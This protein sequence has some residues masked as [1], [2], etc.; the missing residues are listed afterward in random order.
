MGSMLRPSGEGLYSTFGGTAHRPCVG[1]KPASLG[2]AEA[3]ALPLTA[4]TAYE[5]L[6]DRLDRDPACV[7]P[8]G[9]DGDCHG[10]ATA[11]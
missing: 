3:A 8:D 5:M 11:D 6:F 9:P 4:T 1:R 2:D 7:R 10:L